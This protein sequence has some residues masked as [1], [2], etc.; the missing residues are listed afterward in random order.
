MQPT[1]TIIA[2]VSIGLVTSNFVYQ[3]MGNGDYAAAMERS[4]FQLVAIVAVSVALALNALR[5]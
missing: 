1:T 5:A 3:A 4:V 2:A